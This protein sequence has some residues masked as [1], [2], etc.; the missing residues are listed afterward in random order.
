MTYIVIETFDSLYPVIVTD[1]EGM[2]IIFDEKEEAEI[3]AAA[4][5]KG[6]VV[7]LP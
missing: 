7:E 4:C 5:Q 3:E 1:I 2:P 6:I